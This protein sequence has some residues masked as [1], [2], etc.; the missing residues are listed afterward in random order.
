[1]DH[2]ALSST[3]LVAI[4]VHDQLS[5]VTDRSVARLTKVAHEKGSEI[6]FDG[7]FWFCAVWKLGAFQ[8]LTAE[9]VV[10]EDQLT[11]E[12]RYNETAS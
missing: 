11:I 4:F 12:W 1:M 10:D 2:L 8:Q 9:N 3:N 6:R 5:R 7:V